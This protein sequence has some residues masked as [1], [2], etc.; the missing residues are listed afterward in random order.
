MNEDLMIFRSRILRETRD[1]FTRKGFLEV[2]TPLL[3]PQLIPEGP[4]APF[5]TSFDPPYGKSRSLYLIPSPELWMK[6]ILSRGSPSIFQICKSFRNGESLGRHHNPEFT[7]L[8]YYALRHNYMDSMNLTEEFISALDGSFPAPFDRISLPD[9]F[10]RTT[11]INLAEAQD[12]TSLQN[13]ARGAG[14]KF[15][16]DDSWPDIFDR[17]FV[18]RVEPALPGNK[19]VFLYDYPAKVPVLAKE[20]SGTPWCERWE[21]YYKGIEIANCY[22]EEDDPERVKSFYLHESRRMGKTGAPPDKGFLSLFETPFPPCSGTA[23]GMDRLIMVLSGIS[24]IKGVIF[25]PLSDIL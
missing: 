13:E 4:I 17:I 2:D 11:G 9:L 20:K 6:R 1:F 24:D 25:F 16:E 10:R 8:E 21:L 19:P 7:M 14:I 3:S 15:Q 18:S 22:T 23:L 12:L 5:R